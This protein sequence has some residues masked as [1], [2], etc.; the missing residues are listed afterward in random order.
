[1]T[2]YRISER[3]DDRLDEIYDHTYDRWG[4]AQAERYGLGFIARF[5]AIAA[6]SVSWRVI[7]AEFGARGYF[8]RYEHH[9]IYWRVLSD[10]SVGIITILHERMHRIDKLAGEMT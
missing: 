5:E 2:V 4:Q 8:C 6:R 7:P 9:Y 10:G 3:A 1:M